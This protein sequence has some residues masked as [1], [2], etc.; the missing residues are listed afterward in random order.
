MD[1]DDNW[2]RFV[3]QYEVGPLLDEY[4]FDNE[5]TAKSHKDR[6]LN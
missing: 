3:I 2:Y 1:G 5:E 4:W 6:L